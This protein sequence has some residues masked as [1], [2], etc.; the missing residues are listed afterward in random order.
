MFDTIRAAAA[1]NDWSAWLNNTESTAKDIL[2]TEGL[3]P[4]KAND[5]AL[6]IADDLTAIMHRAF[7]SV[8][9]RFAA[10]FVVVS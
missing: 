9:S 7:W 8:S 2:E 1:A 3:E 5:P 4:K 10:L 6:A